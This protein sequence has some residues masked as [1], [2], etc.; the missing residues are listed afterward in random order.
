MTQ[1]TLI[2][3]RIV[4]RTV[5][6]SITAIALVIFIGLYAD[7]KNRVQEAYTTRYEANLERVQEDILSVSADAGLDVGLTLIGMHLRRVAVP[8]RLS[9]DH[10]GRAPLAAAR[11]RP[12]L[13]GGERAKYQ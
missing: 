4:I 12:M 10:I 11:T 9:I 5:L 8:V 1:E 2:R 13:V 7:E 3:Q 6:F